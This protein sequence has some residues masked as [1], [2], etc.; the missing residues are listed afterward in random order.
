MSTS[1]NIWQICTRISAEYTDPYGFIH[2]TPGQRV[3]MAS[4]L[5]EECTCYLGS[6]Y[7]WKTRLDL[8]LSVKRAIRRREEREAA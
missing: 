2:A 4:K 1:E 8:W 5:E 6:D 3:L 7:G